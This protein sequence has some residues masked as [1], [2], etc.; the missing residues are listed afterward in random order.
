MF[1]F[2]FL[3]VLLAIPIIAGFLSSLRERRANRQQSAAFIGFTA[4][5]VAI[6]A[7]IVNTSIVSWLGPVRF[8][9]I[10]EGLQT[11]LAIFSII[12]HLST[13][14]AF[15]AGF[16]TIGIRRVSLIIFGPVIFFMYVVEAFSNFGA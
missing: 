7:M 11:S 12:Q 1:K 2:L 10:G 3:A 14:V 13:L 6:A 5:M 4:A 8:R 16:F 15:C 9:F